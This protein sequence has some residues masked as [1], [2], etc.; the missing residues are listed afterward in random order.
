MKS[1]FLFLLLPLLYSCENKTPAA[2]PI[3]QQVIEDTNLIKRKVANP[4]LPVDISPM[5]MVYFPGDFP[6][7]KMNGKAGTLPQARLVYSRPHRQGRKIFGN[8]VKWGEP[9][10]LGANEATEIQLFQPATIQK[11]RIEKG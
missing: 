7:Q 9:W 10:R 5:D 4:Y 3:N 1:C 11:K 2:K 6:V 8:I